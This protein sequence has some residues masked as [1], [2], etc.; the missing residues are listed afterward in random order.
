MRLSPKV[1]GVSAHPNI[2]NTDIIYYGLE[3]LV[4][5]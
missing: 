4:S 2:D 3:K 1:G 5:R